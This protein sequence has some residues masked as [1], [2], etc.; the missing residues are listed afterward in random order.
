MLTNMRFWQS[1]QWNR[2]AVSLYPAHEAPEAASPGRSTLWESVQLYR[3]GGLF[4]A[5]VTEGSRT[6]L[7]YGLLC[8]L[9]GAPSR[10][11]MAEVFI[12]EPR[13]DDPAQRVKNALFRAVAARS[14]GILTNSSIEAQ[15]T[16]RRYR[17]P[18]SKCIFVPMHSNIHDPVFVPSKPGAPA[19]A[20]GRSLRDYSTL[21][22][23]SCTVDVPI[24]VIG[25]T[26]RLPAPHRLER[27]HDVP[28]AEYLETVRQAS[29][30]IV[31]L[32]PAERSTGQ[33]VALEAMGLGK[34]VIATRAAG[35]LDIIEHEHTGL[36]V[37]PFRADQLA[38]AIQRVADHPDWAAE[39][40]RRAVA[41]VREHATFERHAEHKLTAVRTLLEAREGTR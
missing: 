16:A 11:I 34:P 2:H 39:M 30:V 23:A 27:L 12:D 3:K 1:A 7:L 24:R 31:P 5:V 13:P 32:R 4:D 26:G 37:D 25:R 8:M 40:G 33:V 22:E 21:A 18:E 10:Q 19:L 36:L 14:L 17:I 28:Y 38:E 35:T 15:S 41:Y 6:S 9:T 20:A 29:M